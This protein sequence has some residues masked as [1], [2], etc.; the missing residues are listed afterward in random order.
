MRQKKTPTLTKSKKT[1][2]RR[3]F[4]EIAVDVRTVT[5]NAGMAQCTQ[6]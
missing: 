1:S 2:P 3:S 4:E 5:H 6:S